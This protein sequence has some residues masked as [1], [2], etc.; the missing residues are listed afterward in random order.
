MSDI[1]RLLARRRRVQARLPPFAEIVR[2]SVFTRQQRCGKPTCHCARGTPH[3]ATYLG[4]S[5]AGGRTVQVSLP[6]ALVATARRWVAN[7][8][9]WWKAIEAVSAIN[10]DLLRRRGVPPSASAAKRP[11]GRPRRGRRRSAG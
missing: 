8:E 1:N 3:R 7:Y 10:R 6:P 4:V 9:T 11:P 2:G 5:F